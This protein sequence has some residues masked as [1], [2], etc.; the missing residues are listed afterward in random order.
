MHFVSICLFSWNMADNRNRTWKAF[1]VLERR[2]RKPQEP[3]LPVAGN[4]NAC[5]THI[6][7]TSS[8]LFGF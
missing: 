2:R 6:Y 7:R 3:D 8:K 5:L 4:L 1:I